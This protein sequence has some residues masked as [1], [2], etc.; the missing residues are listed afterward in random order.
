MDQ[1]AIIYE[2]QY[3][4]HICVLVLNGEFALNMTIDG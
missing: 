3:V 1:T 4:Y 2:P